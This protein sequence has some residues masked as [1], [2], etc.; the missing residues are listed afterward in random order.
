MRAQ[1]TRL[2]VICVVA[3]GAT[4]LPALA[5]QTP[6]APPASAK[7]LVSDQIPATVTAW[8]RT[9]AVLRTSL[10]STTAEQRAA[11]ASARIQSALERLSP[12]DIRYSVVE[13]G[14]DRGALIVGAAET[15]F[16]ILEGDLPQDTATTLDTAG[17]QA[18]NRLQT[19]LRERSA[20]RP[21][22]RARSQHR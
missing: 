10:G 20:Q 3:L 15:L 7:G 14:G 4:A 2:I 13:V 5:Q 11:A 1:F 21:G 8:N 18:V 16:A 17:A 9:L 6:P 19:V 22:A 12:D